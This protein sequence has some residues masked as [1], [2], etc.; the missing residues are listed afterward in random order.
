MRPPAYDVN[1][2]Y[3]LAARPG[4]PAPATREAETERRLRAV[5]EKLDR[6]LKALDLPRSDAPKGA[7]RG[8]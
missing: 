7:P 6:I 5:E 3:P 4:G 2:T 1:V 8:S